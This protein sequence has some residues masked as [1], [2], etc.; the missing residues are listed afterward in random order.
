MM[1]VDCGQQRNCW[2]F[3][4]NLSQADT[5]VSAAKRAVLLSLL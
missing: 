1:T 4:R 5:L 3:K 2:V